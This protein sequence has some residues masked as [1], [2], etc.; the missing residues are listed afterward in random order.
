MAHVRQKAQTLFHPVGTCRMGQGLEAV[1]DPALRG[2]GVAGLRVAD[3]SVIPR[4]TR[5]H[6]HAPAVMIAERAADLIQ[7]AAR[8]GG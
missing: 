2:Y 8:K 4:I 5:G 1:V 6:T 7:E 3:A